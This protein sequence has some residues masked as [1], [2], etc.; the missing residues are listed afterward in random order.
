MMEIY[1]R[2]PNSSKGAKS[3]CGNAG[4]KNTF[5]DSENNIEGKLTKQVSVH[6]LEKQSSSQ[7]RTQGLIS[8]PARSRCEKALA[9]AGHVSP[10]FW[11]MTK[12]NLVGG[13]GNV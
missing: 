3:P 13:D 4:V 8:A 10:R 2:K 11:V 6:K 1:E 9:W 5:V 7:L 12:N